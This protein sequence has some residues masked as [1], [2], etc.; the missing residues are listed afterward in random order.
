MGYQDNG[1]VLLV[2]RRSGVCSYRTLQHSFNSLRIANS[3]TADSG[4]GLGV[5][6]DKARS[7]FRDDRWRRGFNDRTNN[8]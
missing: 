1:G 2:G 7:R 4:W 8:S 3:G 5:A 6:V